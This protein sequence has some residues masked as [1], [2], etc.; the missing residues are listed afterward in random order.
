M[1]SLPS[2]LCLAQR[3]GDSCERISASEASRMELTPSLYAKVAM[4][5]LSVFK[6]STFT[7]LDLHYSQAFLNQCKEGTSVPL[8]VGSD[9]LAKAKGYQSGFGFGQHGLGPDCMLSVELGHPW[10]RKNTCLSG[11]EALWMGHSWVSHSLSSGSHW[12][13]S[14]GEI[15]HSSLGVG[16]R[17][18]GTSASCL[19]V[20]SLLL[21]PLPQTQATYIPAHLAWYLFFVHCHFTSRP[22]PS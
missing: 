21:P 5:C 3:D 14:G 16:G 22:P 20:W 1:F 9:N 4:V 15:Y 10:V 17:G 8:S 2:F 7:T 12:A 13:S 19:V 6:G 11:R 18:R